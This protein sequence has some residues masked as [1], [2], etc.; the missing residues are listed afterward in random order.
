MRSPPIRSFYESEAAFCAD[1]LLWLESVPDSKTVPEVHMTHHADTTRRGR[2]DFVFC[3]GGYTF[4]I[5]CK[6]S[7]SRNAHREI[8]AGWRQSL[9]YAASLFDDPR[10]Q[11]CKRP[12]LVVLACPAV[13]LS[14]G[15]QT[16]GSVAFGQMNVGFFNWSEHDGMRICR[17]SSSG[18]QV[19]KERDW[20]EGRGM[21]HLAE[22]LRDPGV[23]ASYSGKMVRFGK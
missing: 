3:V 20:K 18:A 7:G 2:V 22:K 13:I 15:Y 14:N 8:A 5:E 17:S 1:V 16:D 11:W 23:T 6:P 21:S 12:H 10:V 19:W 9:W 4:A